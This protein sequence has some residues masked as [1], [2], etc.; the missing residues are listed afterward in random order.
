MTLWL[1]QLVMLLLP[2]KVLD[3]SALN[4][5]HKFR[6]EG[7]KG[8]VAAINELETADLGVVKEERATR[9]T[10]KVHYVTEINM[11]HR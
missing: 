1:E 11:R 2:G 9:G 7:N 3:I 8:A 4:T 5:S 6:G 10:T